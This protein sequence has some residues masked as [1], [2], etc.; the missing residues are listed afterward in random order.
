MRAF[1]KRFEIGLQKV[2][3]VQAKI[4]LTILYVI[5]VVP[6][7]LA[8]NAVEDVLGLRTKRRNDSYWLPKESGAPTLAQGRRQG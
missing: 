6:V 8:T 1:W 4:I 5:F 3:D 2:A 7:G